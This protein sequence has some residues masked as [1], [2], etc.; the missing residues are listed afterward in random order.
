MLESR[1]ESQI[2]GFFGNLEWKIKEFDCIFVAKKGL[3]KK[4]KRK[5]ERVLNSDA[6][7]GSWNEFFT[8]VKKR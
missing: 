4:K 6:G 7:K 5:L 1:R 3:K 8:E 2:L